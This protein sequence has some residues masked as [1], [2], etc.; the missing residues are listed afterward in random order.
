[1]TKARATRRGP[2]NTLVEE[3]HMADVRAKLAEKGCK[4]LKDAAPK[5]GLHYDAF[6][7]T[8]RRG[9]PDWIVEALA[10]VENLKN[11]GI[12]DMIPA[13]RAG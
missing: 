2:Q 12:L 5:S 10:I 6:I 1:M 4:T 8:C 3:P 13:K 11:L 7:K 9:L